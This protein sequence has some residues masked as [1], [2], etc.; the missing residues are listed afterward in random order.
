MQMNLIF[1]EIKIM[2]SLKVETGIIT[3]I[4]VSLVGQS[5]DTSDNVQ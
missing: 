2:D 4:T 1:R 5:C 3:S